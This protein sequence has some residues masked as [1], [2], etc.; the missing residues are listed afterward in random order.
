MARRGIS[1]GLSRRF[2][3]TRALALWEPKNRGRSDA[4]PL[5]SEA[6]LVIAC[7]DHLHSE[8]RA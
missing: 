3:V 7:A 8:A 4:T 6:P 2:P 1:R 5:G